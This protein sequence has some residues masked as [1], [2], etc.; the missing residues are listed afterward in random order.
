MMLPRSPRPRNAPSL[1]MFSAPA[2]CMKTST[3]SS[4]ALAQNGS[5]FGSERSSPLTWPPMDAPRKPRRRTPSCELFGGQLGMLQR[6]GRQRDKAIGVCRH[7]F[8]QS[9]VLSANDALCEVVVGRVP[10]VAVDAQR[11]NVDALLIH[12]LQPLSGPGRC[13]RPRLPSSP[14]ACL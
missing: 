8:R 10:P 1:M 5:Y 4:A 12:D 2:G 14:A 11:L 3:P 9:L 13:S 7:P 6:D